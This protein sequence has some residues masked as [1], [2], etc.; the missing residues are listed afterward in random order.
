MRYG[1]RK[2]AVCMALALFL[3]MIFSVRP[4]TA[5]LA[6]GAAAQ[7]EWY[8]GSAETTISVEAGNQF[9]IG[10]FVM[11]LSGDSSATASLIKASYQS[12]SSKIASVNQKGSLKAKKAGAADITVKYQG[13][14]VVCHL[15]VEKKGAFEVNKD[16]AVTELK[17]AAKALAKG[18]PKKLGA[19]KGYAFKQ[20]RDKYLTAYETYSLKKL[21]YDGF[22]YEKERPAPTGTADYNRSEKLAVPQAG[23][24]LT[25]ESLLRQ[26]RQKNDP[27][28]RK[29]AGAMQIS[30]ASAAAK[31]GKINI[32][33]K[34]KLNSNQILAA[35]LAFPAQNST[36]GS[37]SKANIQMSIYDETS[38]TYYKGNLTL[39]KG[40]ANLTV[41]PMSYSGG[42]YKNAELKKGHVYLLGS[43]MNWANGYRITAK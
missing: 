12:S 43:S 33:L 32:K 18:M 37:K 34:K 19:A 31:S 35:Q 2:T 17:A 13:R 30:S 26:F 10:D 20:K 9:Y 40:S 36:I 14:S 24:Y 8:D 16:E 28:S 21:S 29:A 4:E 6:Y 38:C 25:A 5:V 39:K 15:T 11:V 22:L 3:T 23:R 27:T 42:V 1:Q 41:T 7:L